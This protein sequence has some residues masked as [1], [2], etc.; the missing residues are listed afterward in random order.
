LW[1]AA[2]LNVSNSRDLEVKKCL[3]PTLLFPVKEG[4]D[5]VRTVS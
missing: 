4:K 1:A 3:R 5:A 2:A